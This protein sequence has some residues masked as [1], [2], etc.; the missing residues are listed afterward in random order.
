[1]YLKHSDLTSKREWFQEELVKITNTYLEM[2]TSWT[3]SIYVNNEKY[4]G[5]FYNINVVN[6]KACLDFNL[7]TITDKF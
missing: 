2:Y 7:K 1:M 3:N 5:F 4:Q 6:L